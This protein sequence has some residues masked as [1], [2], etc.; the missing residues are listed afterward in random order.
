M[1]PRHFPVWTLFGVVL[2]VALIVG[3]GVLSSAPPT[4]IQRAYAIE[5]VVRC[6]SCEDLSVA[7]SSAP[8]AIA[9]RAA[10]VQ[11]I[12]QGRTDQ[13]IKTYLMDRYGSSIVLDPPASG[14]SLVVWLLPLAGGLAAAAMLV[15]VLIR[16]RGAAVGVP[17]DGG[18]AR[19]LTPDVAEERRRFLTR[20]LADAD[21]EYLA[22]D[23]SDKD[24]LALRHRDMVR[25][26]ALEPDTQEPMPGRVRPSATTSIITED[27]EETPVDGQPA[28]DGVGAVDDP[29]AERKS[30]SRR[31]RWFLGGAVAA[32]GAS[33]VMVVFLFASSRQ[34]GQSATGSFAQTPQQQIEETLAEAASSENQGD[35]GQAATLY[36]SVLDKHPD[37]EVAL[38]QLGWLEYET[39]RQGNATSLIGDA[40]AKLDRAVQLNPHDYAVRLY[41]GTILLQQDGNAAGA[42]EQYRLFLADSP[43]AALVGQAATQIRQAYQKDGLP[44]PTQVA[45]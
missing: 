26:A 5:T 15:T 3:S 31:S 13:Q 28:N 34:P 20:S 4:A 27:R 19:P 1:T 23:L 6:P 32:F 39:S 18:G 43:P 25:L 41:L 11:L 14:W 17:D 2:T 10:V 35:A 36:Q 8:T 7:Q 29:T 24:Y 12:S 22:G 21:A 44:V 30:R 33:L 37:N 38:A 42:V 16:R 9:V 40:R 45:G